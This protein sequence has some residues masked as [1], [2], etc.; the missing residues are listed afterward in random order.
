MINQE[1]INEDAKWDGLKEYLTNTDLSAKE[2][3]LQLIEDQ[4]NCL[5]L[6]IQKISSFHSLILV[7]QLNKK[8]HL[9]VESAVP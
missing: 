2:V 9:I 4:E 8:L 1:K 5:I 3:Y 6:K 7:N